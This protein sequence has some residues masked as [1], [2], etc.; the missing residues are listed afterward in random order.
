MRV[1]FPFLAL[2]LAAMLPIAPVSGSQTRP[3][4]HWEKSDGGMSFQ[5]VHV[6]STRGLAA[7]GAHF[8]LF[9]MG[10]AALV[11]VLKHFRRLRSARAVDR[12]R[13]A[14]DQAAAEGS[15]RGARRRA[16]ERAARAARFELGRGLWILLTIALTAPLVGTLGAV[17]GLRNLCRGIA[18]LGSVEIGPVDETLA[19]VLALFQFS[20]EIGIPSFWAYAYL[21]ARID[22]TARAMEA[23]VTDLG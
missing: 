3:E 21:R 7:L 10:L 13:K 9:L 4:E 18:L 1:A 12:V 2:V 19:E 5:L 11:V 17:A 20:L 22:R 15:D 8:V 16:M 14:G 6:S 23:A